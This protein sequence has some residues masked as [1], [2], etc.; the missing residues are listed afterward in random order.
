M[1]TTS[2]TRPGVRAAAPSRSSFV[3]GGL[4]A[5]LVNAG[6]WL[7]GRAADVTFLAHTAF[8][9]MTVGILEILLGTV[10]MFAVGAGLLVWAIRRSPAWARAVLVSA[11]LFAVLSAV[12]PLTLAE[13]TSSGALLAAMHLAT[14][15]AFLATASRARG[16][17]EA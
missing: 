13:D 1:S 10:V 17:V 12:G 5:A 6:L 7:A 11:A 4:V 15:A 14:G 16:S 8:G 9:E 3:V 2:T